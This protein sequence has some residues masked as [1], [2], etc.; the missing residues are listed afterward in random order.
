[1]DEIDTSSAA[2][3]VTVPAATPTE[4]L[5]TALCGTAMMLPAR[6]PSIVD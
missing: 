3:A 6:R 2:P 4:D 5:V 1:M